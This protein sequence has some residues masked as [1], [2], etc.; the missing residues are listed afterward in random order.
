MMWYDPLRLAVLVGSGRPGRSGT[1]V[2]R[3][4]AEAA[5]RCDGL[6]T[7]VVDLAEYPLPA[8]P[9]AVPPPEVREVLAGLT[10]RLDRADV[11]VVVTPEYNRSFPATLKTAVDWHDSEWQAKPV[12][13]VSYGGRSGGLRAVE[14]L[15]QVFGEVH[16][17]PVRDGVSF[18]GVGQLFDADG[19][20]ADPVGS[21]AAARLLLAE[22]DWWG[23]VLRE[24]RVHHPYPH[25]ARTPAVSAA[26]RPA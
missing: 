22:L 17:V 5:R 12:G 26:P 24:G 20:P 2:A 8:E 6:E 1:A 13:F 23:R 14:Q 21:T 16:A 10:P 18:H 4:F 3:W 19:R 9:V 7:D 11:F 15:R 25:G